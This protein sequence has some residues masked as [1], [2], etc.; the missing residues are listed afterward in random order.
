MGE[1]VDATI[2]VEEIRNSKDLDRNK[3][4]QPV[5]SKEIQVK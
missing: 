3:T 1:V 4:K 5:N 2:L